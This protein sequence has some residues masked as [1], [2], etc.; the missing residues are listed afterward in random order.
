[1]NR[2]YP[3][4][5][6]KTGFS[7]WNPNHLFV[8]A[9]SGSWSRARALNYSGQCG[10]VVCCPDDQPASSFRW[11]VSGLD[12]TVRS[13]DTSED[14]L[15]DLAYELLKADANLVIVIHGSKA[16]IAVYRQKEIADAA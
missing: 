2:C 3:P 1:M 13:T 15:E 9:G 12:V 11:P 4:F 16:D 10:A 8:L 6:K 14:A 5:A 7:R